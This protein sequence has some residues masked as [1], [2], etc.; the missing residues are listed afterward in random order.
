MRRL[1]FAFLFTFLSASPAF[2]VTTCTV[3]Q[4]QSCSS[5]VG[6]E[7]V[8]SYI[9]V[10][11]DWKRGTY[12]RCDDTGC[13]DFSMKA[14]YS[15]G[16]VNIEVPEHAMFAKISKSNSSFVE[17]ATFLGTVLVSFGSCQTPQ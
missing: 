8:K 7:P 2:A 6:C 11:I 4:K 12:S 3:D 10:H 16:F 17:V 13:N 9:V 15:L 1:L 5:G 14:S